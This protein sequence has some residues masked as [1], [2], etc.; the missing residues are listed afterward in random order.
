MRIES[1]FVVSLGCTLL[2]GLAACGVADPSIEA[3]EDGAKEEGSMMMAPEDET[4]EYEAPT[5]EAFRGAYNEAS[6]ARDRRCDELEESVADCVA[7]SAEEFGAERD[8][9]QLSLDAMR[10]SYSPQGAS[11]CLAAVRG[12]CSTS[13]IDVL[14][15]CNAALSGEVAVG[16]MCTR[17]SDCADAE[18]ASV[19]GPFCYNGCEPVTGKTEQ[20]G[21][22]ILKSPLF[23]PECQG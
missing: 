3:V 19:G 7:A 15:A 23:T 13:A 14:I 22:C 6:C 20:T 12:A 5:Y 9:I 4:P 1:S 21:V 2:L 16:E 8:K 11:D 10:M 17:M 18:G